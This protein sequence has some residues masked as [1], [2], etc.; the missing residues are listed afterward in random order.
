M[1]NKQWT[2]LANASRSSGGSYYLIRCPFCEAIVKAY[3]WSLAGSGKKCVCGALFTAFNRDASRG[4][5]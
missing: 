5:E 1:E 4:S 2:C 3:K